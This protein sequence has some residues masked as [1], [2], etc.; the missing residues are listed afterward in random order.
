M[1]KRIGTGY[2]KRTMT[3]KM[4]KNDRGSGVRRPGPWRGIIPPMVTPLSGPDEL[5]EPGLERLIAH[6]LAG[7]VH[8]LFI[9]GTTGEGPA[10]SYRLRRE[11]IRSA[12]REVNG[13]VPV[14][15]GITDTAFEESVA[16]ARF[17]ADAGAAAVV[18]APPYYLPL[19]QP[20]LLEYLS[21]LTARLPLP[22]MLYNM[23]SCTKVSFDPET[24][25][26]AAAI[27]GI[28]GLKDS[29][30]NADY[31]RKVLAVG[32]EMP[33]FAIFM[34]PEEKL[35][36]AMSLGA[37]G[38]VPGGANLCPELYV[39][40]YEAALAGDAAR[41]APLQQRVMAVSTALYGMGRHSS[42]YLK[43]VKCALAC[44]GICGDF[45]AEPF[46]RFREPE[47]AAI[48]K[49]LVELKLK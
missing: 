5:D 26:A 4:E 37:S 25:R 34:G 41:L 33:D 21:H 11:L 18:A 29:S 49:R 23:P 32:R 19:G 9:L 35:A 1:D 39:Q 36:E 40:L 16:L 46:H 45:L 31:F 28:A 27:P 13:R 22:L 17:A 47:R 14:L 24:V 30:G 6:I 48:E 2:K 3:V 43:G 38:G 7:G 20:E 12:C 8:G 10:L 42:S 15:V 44:L